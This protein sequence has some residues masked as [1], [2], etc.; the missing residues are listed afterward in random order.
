MN[1]KD[2]KKALKD[3]P[4][5]IEVTIYIPSLCHPHTREPYMYNVNEA[6]HKLPSGISNHEFQITAGGGFDY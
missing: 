5:E 6:G 1:V 2:L 4:D 3:I